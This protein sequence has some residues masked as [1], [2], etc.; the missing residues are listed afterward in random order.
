MKRSHF[1]LGLA[2]NGV[3]GLTFI[4]SKVGVSEFPPLFFSALRFALIAIVLLPWLRSPGDQLR[5]VLLI[6]LVLGAI[7]F[8]VLYAGIAVAGNI[9]S[10]AVAVQLFVPFSV[11]IAVLCYGERVEVERWIGMTVAFLGILILSFDPE[12]LRYWRGL[13][14]VIA[15]AF[16][17]AIGINL[18]RGLR[19]VGVYQLQAWIAAVSTP[20]LFLFSWLFESGQWESLRTANRYGIGAVFYTAIGATLIGHAGW[21]YLLQRYPVGL[22]SPF[23][24]LAPVFGVVFGVLLL[25]D[26]FGLR[27]ALGAVVTLLGV[28][29]IF[30]A[31]RLATSAESPGPGPGRGRREGDPVTGAGSPSPAPE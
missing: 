24:L 10:V 18:M 30:R 8:G 16:L 19:G 6:A 25:G 1:A 7:H 14:L 23:G 3:W 26:R 15:S 29:V 31:Q 22:L 4:A 9:S 17:Y 27:F 13:G 2:I 5:P 21:Y 20:L 12:V 28:A 11:L